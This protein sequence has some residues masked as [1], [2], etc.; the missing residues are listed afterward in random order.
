MRKYESHVNYFYHDIFI[1]T[2]SAHKFTWIN[3]FPSDSQSSS[4]SASDS[5]SDSGVSCK[6]RLLKVA[7]D[8]TLGVKIHPGETHKQ[9]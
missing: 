3:F 9:F 5:A 7:Q 8:Q 6:Y 4:D 2:Y 1:F